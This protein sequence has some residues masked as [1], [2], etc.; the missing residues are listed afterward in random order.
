MF[1][2]KIQI[3]KSENDVPHPSDN[4]NTRPFLGKGSGDE[5]ISRKSLGL[6]LALTLALAPRGLLE[7]SIVQTKEMYIEI[8]RS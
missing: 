7:N 1:C 3:L 2:T 6:A 5:T 4:R 8:V